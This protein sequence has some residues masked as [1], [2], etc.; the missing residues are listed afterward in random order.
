MPFRAPLL[1]LMSA[2]TIGLVACNQ[3]APPSA[4]AP[5][6]QATA[7]PAQAPT[8]T[9]A[10]TRTPTPAPTPTATPA[11]APTPTPS[12]T[13]TATPTPTPTPTPIPLLAGEVRLDILQ[14]AE[15]AY[16]VREQL[17]GFDF[18]SDAVGVTQ[19]IEGFIVLG[20]DGTV[21][22]HRSKLTIDLR[23][24]V[25]DE[26]RR[27]NFIRRRVLETGLFPLAVFVPNEARGL[28]SPCPTRGRPPSSSWE[29]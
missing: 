8:P 24:L 27:D 21:Q 13:P 2:L 17:L 16:M 28:P 5:E 11:P 23:T 6:P 12:P 25:S 7:A 3:A 1:A 4:P 20:A 9:A 26:D 22:A 18:P 14:G 19:D 15:A 29:T 10:P